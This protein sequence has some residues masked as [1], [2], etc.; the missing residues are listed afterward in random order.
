VCACVEGRGGKGA[1]FRPALDTAAMEPGRRRRRRRREGPAKSA[2]WRGTRDRRRRRGQQTFGIAG[3]ARRPLRDASLLQDGTER[4]VD[5]WLRRKFEGRLRD[6]EVVHKEDLDL[7]RGRGDLV[8][9]RSRHLADVVWSGGRA[10]PAAAGR[11]QRWIEQLAPPGQAAGLFARAQEGACAAAG[12]MLPCAA[13]PPLT[14]GFRRR[15]CLLRRKPLPCRMQKNH[16][17]GLKRKLL[18]VSF[19][20]VQ[21]LME[22]SDASGS[23]RAAGPRGARRPG[24]EG[25]RAPAGVCL[26]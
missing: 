24:S 20:N 26:L 7:V 18:K 1:R 23:C 16:L 2:P 5:S 17:S 10:W 19:W 8:I 21:Q 22:A 15:P 25:R 6:I 3:A 12:R 4:D 14:R 11:C 13:E 9:L